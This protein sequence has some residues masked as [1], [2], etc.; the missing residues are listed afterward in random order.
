MLRTVYGHL[1]KNVIA[2][3]AL[4]V[5]LGGTSYAALKL[6]KNSV[7]SA[8]I[9]NGAVVKRDLARAV[10]AQLTRAG[11]PTCPEPLGHRAPRDPRDPRDSRGRR[12]SLAGVARASVTAS[13]FRTSPTSP[14][15]RMSSLARKR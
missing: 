15:A 8:Q 13:T 11:V 10:R 4:F 9:K 2:Y 1:G 5:A 3:L 7:G 6:P 12:D 14:A